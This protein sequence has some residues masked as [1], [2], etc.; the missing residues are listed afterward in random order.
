MK[1]CGSDEEQISLRQRV[2]ALAWP[3]IGENFMQ[4]TLGIVDTLLVSGLGAA[5]LAGVGTAQEV[6][7]LIIAA[8]SALSVGSA[9]LVAQAVG[10][11]E[12]DRASRFAQQSILWSA[13]LGLPLAAAGFLGADATVSLFGLEPDVAQIAADYLRVTVGTAMVLT[14]FT[15]GSGVLRGANDSRT[16]MQITALANVVN[17]VLTYAMI[18]GKWG[19]PAM[20]AVGSAWA[21]FLSRVLALSILLVVLWR[22]RN[23]VRIRGTGSWLPSWRVARRV[24]SIGVPAALEQILTSAA[25]FM[26][27]IVVAHLGTHTLAAH[28]ILFNALS[29][30]LLPGIGFALAA[31]SLVGQSIGAKEPRQGQAA[32][33]IATQGALLWMGAMGLLSVIFAPQIIGLY[34]HEPAV[35]R[36][37]TGGLRIMA[38][39]QPLWAI[40]IVQSGALRGMGNTRYPLWVAAGYIWAGVLLGACFVQMFDGGLAMIWSALFLTTAPAAWLLWRQ[41]GRE[42][43]G[44]AG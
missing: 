41:F 14:T 13:L 7:F 22:G 20:G 40:I 38:L 24:M 21:T 32:A 37:G 25:N 1:N 29:L 2:W 30:S 17:F 15:I 4:T 27:A 8:L 10:A 3:V 28:R 9:V 39:L 34:S 18:Y 26:L 23:G 44:L 12:R 16:P 42:V 43:E 33:R 36:A 6:M 31:T 35:I 19:L 5:A 11:L